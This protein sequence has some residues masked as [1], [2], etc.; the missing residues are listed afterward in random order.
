MAYNPDALQFRHRI[1]FDAQA[2]NIKYLS[3]LTTE[4]NSIHN[5]FSFSP[6]PPSPYIQFLGCCWRV[7]FDYAYQQLRQSSKHY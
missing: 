3:V 1:I 7:R 6:P 4:K 5:C 2:Q